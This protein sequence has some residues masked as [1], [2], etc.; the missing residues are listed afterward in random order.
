MFCLSVA[1]SVTIFSGK[2]DIVSALQV[3]D[4]TI[5]TLKE[6][7]NET[8]FKK[9]YDEASKMAVDMGI[10]VSEPRRRKISC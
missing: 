6:M 9:F 3:A 1:V 7:R 5:Q 4:T 8:T 10:E 2:T